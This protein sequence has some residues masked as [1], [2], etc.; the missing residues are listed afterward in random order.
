MSTVEQFIWVI[1]LKHIFAFLLTLSF[2]TLH[3]GQLIGA[4]FTDAAVGLIKS[5]PGLVMAGMSARSGMNV[6]GA[7]GAA[8]GVPGGLNKGTWF[9]KF[10]QLFNGF[11]KTFF[12]Q[13]SDSKKEKIMFNICIELFCRVFFF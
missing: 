4:A 6:S 3:I 13:C 8:A 2:F 11:L 12:A 1:D 10:S 5:V 7:G 9:F